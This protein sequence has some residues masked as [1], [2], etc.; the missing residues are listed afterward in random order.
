MKKVLVLMGGTSQER[1]VSLRS[2]K[3]VAEALRKIGYLVEEMDFGKEQLAEIK[4]INPDV[5]FIA[6][7]GR[8]GE[9]GTVQ[10]YLDLLDI[11]YTGSGLASSAICMNKILTKKMLSYEGLPT[12]DFMILH[13]KTFDAA[14]VLQQNK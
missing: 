14:V 6:L 13:Q 7:H 3:A 5:V 11:P 1:E 9:D 4:A 8:N 2:G 12:A 10:G